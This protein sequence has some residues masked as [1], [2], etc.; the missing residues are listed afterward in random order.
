VD[1]GGVDIFRVDDLAPG[2]AAWRCGILGFSV[3]VGEINV[4]EEVVVVDLL[5]IFI[6]D[7]QGVFFE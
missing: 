5:S 7:L 2:V 4:E 3:F 1:E 6:G